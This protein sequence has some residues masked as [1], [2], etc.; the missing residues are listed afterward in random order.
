[1]ASNLGPEDVSK[2]GVYILHNVDTDQ[3]YI[4][5]GVL[6][7]RMSAH[8]SQLK[9]DNH[10]NKNLQQAYNQNPNF[11]F[12][13]VP[14][15][16]GNVEQD[17]KVALDIEASLITES[18]GN[19]LLLNILLTGVNTREDYSY[20][21][22]TIERLR[23]A[24]KERWQDPEYREKVVA[25]QNAGRA[26]MTNEEISQRNAKLSSSLKDA[27]ASGIR[28]SNAGQIRSEEFCQNNSSKISEKWQDPEYREKQRQARIQGGNMIRP[29]KEVLVGDITY[30]SLSDAG[31]AHGITK[32]SAGYRIKSD[33]YPDWNLKRGGP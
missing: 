12:I 26:A 19:P 11:D 7:R 17:R 2:V 21:E 10:W 8:F 32:Q 1:M 20:S 27:Y 22:K 18:V 13:G 31:K 5:S 25:A 28:Q 33:K 4:G 3:T 9:H 15:E 14:V 6:G 23:Q 30:P 24:T 29:G 16:T